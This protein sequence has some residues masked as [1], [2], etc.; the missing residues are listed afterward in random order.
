MGLL[1]RIRM[2][3]GVGQQCV[4]LC[5]CLVWHGKSYGQDGL[6]FYRSTTGSVYTLSIQADRKILVGDIHSP[7]RLNADGSVD[8]AFEVRLGKFPSPAYTS[9]M[10]QDG[11][12]LLGGDFQSVNGTSVTNLARLNLDGILD[13]NFQAPP[14]RGGIVFALCVD[15]TGR[16]LSGGAEFY[17]QTQRGEGIQR[18]KYDGSLDLSFESTLR[19]IPFSI[20]I[21]A[22]GRILAGGY[23]TM[24]GP[25]IRTNLARLNQDGSLDASFLQAPF[26]EVE[27]TALQ[28]DGTILVSAAP[29]PQTGPLHMLHR[30]KKDGSIDPGFQSD[31]EGVVHA[32]A[33][34]ADGR[35]LVGGSFTNV[36][37]NSQC[38]LVR[39]KADGSLDKIFTQLTN[40]HVYSLALQHDGGIIAGGSRELSPSQSEGFVARFTS[41]DPATENLSSNGSSV[42]WLRGGSAPELSRCKFQMTTNGVDWV[43]LGVG[44][45]GAGGWELDGVTVPPGAKIRGR[46]WPAVGNYNGTSWF[47]ETTNETPVD[48]P[49]ILVNEAEFGI[50]GGQFGFR[51]L[52]KEGQQV[53]LET[54]SIGIYW[55]SLITNTLTS[56]PTWFVDPEPATNASRFYRIRVLP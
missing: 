48:R 22:D 6:D 7:Q 8:S 32:V 19:G 15:A 52:G 47:L 34:Q 10:Q 37:G 38:S 55:T 56:A 45:P 12:V 2:S 4:I 28:S 23:F 27:T 1:S 46:G 30:L 41:D 9:A 20:A 25:D 49:L 33:V 16:I 40:A 17:G 44:K 26:T 50:H 18:L 54:S 51:V 29:F 42:T 13:S 3:V 53:V 39:L 36:Q 5:G 24:S 43:E 31:L 14:Q 35:I 11:N 21:Q